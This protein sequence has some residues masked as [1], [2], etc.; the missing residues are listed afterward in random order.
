MI[1]ENAGAV[2]AFEK[3]PKA[4]GMAPP[5]RKLSNYGEA[6]REKQ[7]IKYYYGLGERTLR[8]FYQEAQRAKG[9]TG[10]NLLL[11]CERRLDSVVRQAGLTKTRPQARQGVGHGHFLVN[12][13]K[14]DIP[15][16]LLRAGDVIHVKRRTHLT[17]FYGGLATENE[18]NIPDWLT[19]DLEQLKIT[20]TRLP[21]VEN[22]TLP[23]NV[24]IV[25]ELLSR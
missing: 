18:G 24:G 14:A 10:Q 22:I 7:K 17:E 3:R 20:V 9:N 6:M 21:A 13:K 1:F 25:I 19:F 4:P 23:V 16:L 8:R 11:L 2:R 5:V 12:G 15:S